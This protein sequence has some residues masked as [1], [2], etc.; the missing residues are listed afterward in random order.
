M[1]ICRNGK[2]LSFQIQQKKGKDLQFLI[3]SYSHLQNIGYIHRDFFIK[4]VYNDFNDFYDRGGVL[5]G[6]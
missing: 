2:V 5:C 4:I 3:V 6:R 1:Y